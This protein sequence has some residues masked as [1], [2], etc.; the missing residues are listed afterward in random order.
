MRYSPLRRQFLKAATAG[1][2]A[3]TLSA[4][5]YARTIGANDRI[6]L[7]I[8]GCGQRGIKAHMAGVH[9]YDKS[10]NLEII[11]VADPWRVRREMAAET[12]AQ[13]YGRPAQQ[14]PSYRHLL[15]LEHI[16][17]VMI[18]SPDHVHTLH[19]EAAAKAGKDAYVEKP[20][21]MDL[22]SLK[23]SC[24]AAKAAGIV[25]QVGTQ[26]RSYATSTGCRE[27]YRSGALGK[28]SRIE[29]HRN[30]TQPYWY[31]YLKEARAADVDW[32]EF[33]HD[34]PSRPFDAGLFTG[35]YGYRE[36]SDGP[37]PG[38]GSHFIDLVNYVTGSQ[39]PVSV[40]AQGTISLWKDEHK[41]TCPDNVEATWIYPEGF[42]VSYSTNFGNSGGNA[43]RIYGEQGVLDLTQWTKPTMSGLGAA[44]KGTL[45][46]ESP[47]PPIDTPD[48]F[49]NWLQCLRSRQTPNASIDAG[50]QH[51]VAVIMAVKAMD[52]GQRQIYDPLRREIRA[53]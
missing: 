23:S 48:H 14:F 22:D 17:A 41:F 32:Q 15:D 36:F 39:F 35:W 33:L 30:S 46:K 7:G 42:L 11:A 16:D 8:I 18:A 24:D 2:T 19:L 21:S 4:R 37:I 12:A 28:V 53:G 9:P 27:L 50:Y 47:V 26:V 25:V 40:V 44:T 3:L 38:F 10:E 6:R 45:G 31:R 43:F 49:L 13:W 5:S 34:R 52:S 29:Q 1:A 20:L 51:A